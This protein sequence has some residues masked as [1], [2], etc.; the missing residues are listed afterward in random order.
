[1]IKSKKG[2]RENIPESHEAI[3]VRER[4]ENAAYALELK[5]AGQKL[6]RPLTPEER[7]KEDSL[8]RTTKVEI[9]RRRAEAKTHAAREPRGIFD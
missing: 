9:E 5:L 2:N 1:M 7:Q 8:A 3:G 6:S 4:A